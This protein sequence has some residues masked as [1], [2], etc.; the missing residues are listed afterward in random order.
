[1]NN[2]ANASDYNFKYFLLLMQSVLNNKPA[3]VSKQAVDWQAIYNIALKHSL[4]GMLYFAIETLPQKE[5]PQ[6][7]FTP[8]L[9]QM[10]QEQ[11]VTDLNL[12]VETERM[13]QLLSSNNI[14][15]MPVKG[16][17]TKSDYPL[18]HLRTM[19]DVDILCKPDDRLKVEEI[20]LSQGYIRE[21]I[22]EKDS[23]FRKDEILHFE[24]H[25]SLL[26]ESSPAYSYFSNV[27]EGA[28]FR[29]NTLIAKMSLEDTYIFML[30]HLANH[31]LF[32]GAGVR[33]YMDVYMFLKNHSD[34]LNKTYVDTVLEEILLSDFEEQTVSICRNWFSGEEDIDFTSPTSVFI[35]NSCTFGRAKVAFLSDTLRNDKSSNFALFNGL[36]RIFN[37]L[38]P[39]VKWM[40]LRYKAV[41]KAVVLY[42]VFVPVHWVQR[43]LVNRDVKTSNIGSYFVSANSEEAE[44]L[45]RTF[46][47]L[48]L[49][50]RI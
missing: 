46:A 22:G 4:A 1:M 10:Y 14:Q 40:R 33:M 18:S 50:K 45:R 21:N 44:E 9:K 36:K 49:E 39:S 31:I 20:F 24:M 26:A 12:S 25:N 8:Y 30:E 42:P 6:G 32:G 16:I 35:L 34:K 27:W 23:S 15:C 41:D 29:D 2:R 43:L 11:I 38:F 5:K 47:S 3:P 19:T 48:G 37:K 17:T 7:N 28:S 13:L